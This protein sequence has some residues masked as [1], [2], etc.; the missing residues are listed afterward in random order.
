MKK[1]LRPTLFV[2]ISV[3]VYFLLRTVFPKSTGILTFL[4]INIFLDAYLWIWVRKTIQTWKPTFRYLTGLLFWFPMLLLVGMVIYGFFSAFLDWNIYIKTY[5]ISLFF[6]FFSCTFFPI[7]FLL[8]AD[9]LRLIR[10]IIHRLLYRQPLESKVFRRLNPLIFTGWIIGGSFFILLVCGM[11]FWQYDFRIRERVI[12]LTQLPKSFDSIRIV[13]F[14]DI[15]LGNWPRKEKLVDAM[16]MINDQRPDLIFFTG[17]MFN[18]C[19]AEGNE[20]RD[21]F[22]RLHAPLGIFAILGNH[23][24][25]DYIKWPSPAA[26]AKNM[27]DLENYYKDLGWTLLRNENKILHKNGDSVAIIG[28]ENWGATRRF[29]RLGDLAKAQK[30]TEGMAVQLLLSHDPSHWEHIISRDYQQIDVTFSGHT[31]GGQVGINILGIHWSPIVWFSKYWGG[32]Y[33]NPL[34][35]VP[36]YLYVDEG[37]GCISYSGRVGILPEITVLVLTRK[38]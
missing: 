18:Y 37:L 9:L 23:D 32:L 15:H 21:I 20:F 13:Q 35:L 22:K 1:F 28:V 6:S 29:Q 11:I 25:G 7:I 26:K 10:I 8:L 31:H 17:D 30:G 2:A 12:G 36:Q 38:E 24:Y 14:S 34:S 5:V 33:Q 16:Q 4:L 19:T 27:K 3:A